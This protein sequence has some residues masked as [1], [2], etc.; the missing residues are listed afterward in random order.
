[1][2]LAG[3]FVCFKDVSVHL[4]YISEVCVNIFRE[5][6]INVQDGP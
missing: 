6:I 1:M 4:L 3:F 5:S 2:N